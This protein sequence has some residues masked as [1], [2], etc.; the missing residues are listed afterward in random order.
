MSRS[1]AR[2][3]GTSGRPGS[4]GDWDQWPTGSAGDLGP[5]ADPAR[6]A[7]HAAERGGRC[8][9]SAVRQTCAARERAIPSGYT[10]ADHHR[11]PEWMKCAPCVI[12][13]RADFLCRELSGVPAA[14]SMASVCHD[15][16][17][18][19]DLRAGTETGGGR[20]LGR[21]IRGFIRNSSQRIARHG[22]H[23]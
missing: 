18:H 16:G 5:V 8:R 10:A 22:N 2:E 15:P 14:H 4:A 11:L 7:V 17:R 21:P 13:I 1:G 3:A 9:G 20:P 12:G 19:R 6:R 23:H